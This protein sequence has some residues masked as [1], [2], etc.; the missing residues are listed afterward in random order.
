MYKPTQESYDSQEIHIESQVLTQ[1]NKFKYLGS[2]VANNRLDAELD[3]Q[4]SNAPKAFKSGS[5][6]IKS[7][8]YRAVFLSTHL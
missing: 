4:T 6:K 7:A 3:T 8:L 5:T 1:V 2:T